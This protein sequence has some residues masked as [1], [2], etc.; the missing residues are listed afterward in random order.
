MVCQRHGNVLCIMTF[1]HGLPHSDQPLNQ[2]QKLRLQ[3]F[4][5]H[6]LNPL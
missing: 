1:K 4:I 6:I 2:L 5:S 3:F